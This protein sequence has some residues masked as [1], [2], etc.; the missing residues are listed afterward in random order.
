MN[1]KE[2]EKL[3]HLAFDFLIFPKILKEDDN[4]QYI[5]LESHEI[6]DLEDY[7]KTFD[8]SY[9]Y[10]NKIYLKKLRNY[11]YVTKGKNSEYFI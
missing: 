10:M 8:I 7:F 5:E 4:G 9:Y 3:K 11:T 1:N 2:V 6:D